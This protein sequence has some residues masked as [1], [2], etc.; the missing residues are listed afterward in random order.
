[1]AQAKNIAGDPEMVH[2]GFHAIARTSDLNEDLGQIEYIFSDKTGTLTQNIM[3][4]RKCFVGGVVYGYGST[5]I[6]KQAMS[7]S[8]RRRHSLE[9]SAREKA[10]AVTTIADAQIHLDKTIHFDDPRLV[11]ELA[12]NGPNAMRIHDFLTLLSVCHT[13]IP[14]TN[15]KTGVVTYRASSPDE[16]ALVKA[17]RCLGYAHRLINIHADVGEDDAIICSSSIRPIL[18]IILGRH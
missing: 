6:A 4:F 15:A 5:E 3:E 8:P 10:K 1:V 14:E 13:V 7:N 12:T 18:M 9:A 17:A 16:E 2:E 11:Q